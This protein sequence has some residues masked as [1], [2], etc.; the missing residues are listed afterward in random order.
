MNRVCENLSRAGHY[1]YYYYRVGTVRV[2]E[3]N[4]GGLGRRIPYGEIHAKGYEMLRCT[5]NSVSPRRSRPSRSY[6]H[7]Y[8]CVCVCTTSYSIVIVYTAIRA[9]RGRRKT[10]N[11]S[12]SEYF[13]S[14]FRITRRDIISSMRPVFRSITPA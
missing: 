11:N 3:N 6:S 9:P 12:V 1:Y 8:V 10:D 13:L 5:A 7:R 2:C 14:V 4:T